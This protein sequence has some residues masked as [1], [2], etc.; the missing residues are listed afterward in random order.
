MAARRGPTCPACSRQGTWWTTPTARRS[1]PPGPAA[2]PPWMPSGT[3]AIPLR[4]RRRLPCRGPATL[5]RRSGRPASRRA[6]ARAFR[7]VP[8]EVVRE[9]HVVRIGAVRVAGEVAE[10]VHEDRA[11]LRP[12]PVLAGVERDGAQRVVRRI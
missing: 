2:S 10:L 6:D 7:Q 11:E 8:A 3:C 1:P 12:V 4:S 9:H 5:P